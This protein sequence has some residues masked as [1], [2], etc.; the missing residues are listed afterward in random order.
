MT[1]AE[2]RQ[3]QLQPLNRLRQRLTAW[4][5]A[6]FSAILLLLGTGLFVV[7]TRQVDQQ[8]DQSLTDATHEIERAAEIRAEEARRARGVVADAVD[9]L[10]V[11]DRTLYLLDARGMPVQP[12]EQPDWVLQVARDALRAGHV[13][14]GHELAPEHMLRVHG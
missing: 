14:T 1:S 8:L 5:V 7:M 13:E 4:Y 12:S 3:V 2:L 11:P 10:R 9:E 6:T